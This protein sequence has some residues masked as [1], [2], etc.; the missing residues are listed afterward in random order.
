MTKMKTPKIFRI[1]NMLSSFYFMHENI[2]R[3]EVSILVPWQCYGM[4]MLFLF[5]Y[6]A[7]DFISISQPTR[8]LEE[9]GNRINIKKLNIKVYK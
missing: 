6:I 4:V 1:K 2:W 5:S 7:F 3:S 9:I 8:L